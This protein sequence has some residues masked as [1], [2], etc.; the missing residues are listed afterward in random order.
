MSFYRPIDD[1]DQE[2]RPKPTF[3]SKLEEDQYYWNMKD[4]RSG[5]RYDI[6][7]LNSLDGDYYFKYIEFMKVKERSPDTFDKV[8]NWD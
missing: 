3:E 6:P 7:M 1:D 8:L 2:N 4:P 5:R